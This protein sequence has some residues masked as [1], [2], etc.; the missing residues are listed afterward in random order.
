MEW[1]CQVLGQGRR[2]GNEVK[3][4]FDLKAEVRGQTGL[5]GVDQSVVEIERGREGK[6]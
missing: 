2:W 6:D 1:D 5:V 3:A 4:K